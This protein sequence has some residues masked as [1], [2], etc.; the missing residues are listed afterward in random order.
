MYMFGEYRKEEESMEEGQGENKNIS[1]IIR[2]LEETDEPLGLYLLGVAYKNQGNNDRARQALLQS[3]NAFPINWSAWLE[4]VD[5]CDE[6][7]L[8]EI[9]NHWMKNFFIA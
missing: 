8:S 9:S 4:L 5:L 2:S 6:S 3:I 1:S 7:T